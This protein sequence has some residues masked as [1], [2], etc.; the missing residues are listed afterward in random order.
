M[1][2]AGTYQN[3]WYDITRLYMSKR[4]GRVQV[5]VYNSQTLD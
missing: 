4:K 1:Q 3:K 2:N 5:Y